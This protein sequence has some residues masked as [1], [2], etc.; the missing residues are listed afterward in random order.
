MDGV[1]GLVVR[2]VVNDTQARKALDAGATGPE[3]K[4]MTD[5]SNAAV[6]AVY[7]FLAMTTPAQAFS[8]NL[9]GVFLPAGRTVVVRTNRR[10]TGEVR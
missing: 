1:G 3:H 4:Q 9:A 6:T 7:I 5:D 8:V 10:S 2:E